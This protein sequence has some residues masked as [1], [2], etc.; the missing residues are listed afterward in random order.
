MRSAILVGILILQASA[1]F[2]GESPAKAD[3]LRCEYQIDPLGIGETQPRLFWEMNDGQRGAKQTAYRIL[4]AT[5]AEKL[6]KDEGDLWDSGKVESG[7]TAQIPYAGRPLTSQMA[8]YWKVRIWDREGNPSDWSKPAL[9]TM[10]LLKPEDYRGK[11]IAYGPADDVA[12][13]KISLDDC[14]WVWYPEPNCR[15]AAAPGRRYFRGKAELSPNEKI[16]SAYF[17]FSAD[18]RAELIVNGRYV[19]ATVGAGSALCFDI[20][21][22][23]EP[24]EISLAIFAENAG[25]SPNPAGIAGKL[26]VNYEKGATATYRIDGSWKATDEDFKGADLR[27]WLQTNTTWKQWLQPNYNDS[28]W[29]AAKVGPEVTETQSLVYHPPRGCPLFR[30]EFS[31]DRPI[32]RATLYMAGLGNLR[33]R[34]NGEPVG[35]DFFCSGWTDFNKRV[36]Y[37]TYDVTGL[38]KQG[39]NALGGI[40]GPGWYAGPIS[41][42]PQ[43]G[44]YGPYPR[45]YAQLEIELADGSRETIAS[46]ETWK[47]AAGPFVQG[48]NYAGEIYDATREIDDW[49]RPGLD[50]SKWRPVI[51]GENNPN[52]LAAFPGASVREVGRVKPLKMTE[53]KPG[54]YVFDLGH[55]FGGV[56]RLKVKGPRG[57]QV[58][59]R[60]A[61][62]LN[63][64]G[65]LYTVN[66]RNARC[67]D[68]YTLRG[69][70]EE[71]FQPQFTFRSFQY[72]E[73]RGYPGKPSLDAIEGVELSA[74]NPT[75]G[76]F[77][78]SN[79]MLN[80]L[81]DNIVRTQ[82]ANYLTIPTDC[83]NREERLGWMGDAQVFTRTA[84]YNADMAAFFTKWLIDVEDAQFPNG[85]FSNVSPTYWDREC[86]IGGWGDAGVICP[87]TIFWV[88]N[89]RRLLE[90]HYPAMTRWIEFCRANSEG[91]LRP[92]DGWGD[93]LGT[94][95]TTPLDV[96][97]TAYFGESAKLT[98]QAAAILGRADDAKKYFELFEQIK[99]AFNKAYV[100]DDGRIKG[101]TQTSY[102]LA[103]Q[104]ELLPPEK[105]ELAVKHLVENI[106]THGGALSCG[107]IGTGY[108]IPVLNRF[109]QSTLAC[110]LLESE[111][112]P[113]WGFCIKNGATSLWE[114]W[115]GWTPE[116]DFANPTMNSFSHPAFGSVGQS[117]FQMLGGIDALEPGFA[118]IAIAPKP[119]GNID[120]VRAGY[121]SLHGEIL[122]AWK[123]ENGR[124]TLEVTVPANTTAIIEL[125]LRINKAAASAES[126]ITES[127]KLLKDA[128]NVK[129]LETKD[130]TSVK[131]Q[132]DAG[133]Y[134]FEMPWK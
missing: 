122:S 120:W 63:P 103:L 12:T 87:C 3:Y 24:G 43:G 13:P 72:V 7:E 134:R 68:K 79:P 129:I 62:R 78:C 96:I 126:F 52:I 75:A 85:A 67:I 48:E 58:E 124:L 86:G 82:K 35:K 132:I 20:A 119:E 111:K 40:L 19:A 99:T 69:E 2:C 64:D 84:T 23:L 127:G 8:C 112:F 49:D 25:A 91:L 61:E 14:R 47:T 98:A 17:V 73:L 51:A 53:P 65:T 104:F 10:G 114:R 133:K 34:L 9:W 44:I 38:V 50:D 21:D 109:G 46:D 5:T 4:A 95:P 93:W 26:V 42:I 74:A 131:V 101:D 27:E 66:L 81:F 128:P 83:P 32:R 11:W 29:A 80:R 18:D 123:K 30:K 92:N 102:L 97:G 90:R 117:L 118:K 39:P 31:L 108:L 59:I 57:T 110:E 94:D 115:D 54:R 6:E 71:I 56:V 1:A 45:L 89:D 88:Y 106:K 22:F 28:A 130:F 70:G 37:F 113:S 33:M 55:N 105:R 121:R 125:P 77:E 107:I 16:E 41:T 15:E 100:S 36:Y 76:S 116:K 60:T